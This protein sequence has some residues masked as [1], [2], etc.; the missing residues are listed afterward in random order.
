M[1]E[2]AIYGFGSFFN[3]KTDFQDIDILILHRS[4]SHKSCQFSLWCK[5]YF[6]SNLSGADI[7]VLSSSEERQFAFLEKSKAMYLGKVYEKSAENDI[8]LILA[9]VIGISTIGRAM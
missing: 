2:V 5:K 1:E 9:K 6:L 7:T 8:D 3:R 4:T